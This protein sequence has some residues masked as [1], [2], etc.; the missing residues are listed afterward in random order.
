[1]KITFFFEHGQVN[2]IGT[3]HLYRTK[4]LSEELKRRG[5]KISNVEDGVLISDNDVLVIDHMFPQTDLIQRAKAAGMKVVLIDGAAQDASSVDTSISAFVNP[6]ATHKGIYY[7]VFPTNLSWDKYRPYKKSNSV[8]IG[9]GGYD[10]NNYAK[11]AIEV[12]QDFGM[13]AIVAKSLNHPNFKEQYSNVVMFEEE[14]YYTAMRECIIGIVNGG[15]TLFQALYYGLPCVAIP[16][17]EH[18][19]NNIEYVSHC[20]LPAEPNK[21][22]LKLKISWLMNSEYYREDLS[23][24]AQHYID[25]KGIARV[26]SLIEGLDESRNKDTIRTNT[27]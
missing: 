16:Q 25:G 11:M 21:E 20:C 12:L 18:Q 4:V 2:E 15:L 24:L 19:N 23:R 26:C 13:N 10:A 17:Y 22:D 5:H 14:D 8:F 7:V 27:N 9:M 6:A 1:M 3:G